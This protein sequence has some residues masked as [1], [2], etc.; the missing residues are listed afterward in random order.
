MT[1]PKD[2]ITKT[3]IIVLVLLGL[4]VGVLAWTNSI[5]KA[6]PASN[7][8]M[9]ALQLAITHNKQGILYLDAG[10]P[11]HAINE[12]KLGIMLNPNSTMS[13][14]LYNNLG[15]SYEMIKEYNYAITAYEHAI[16]INPNFSV[17]YK[18][19][20]NVYKSKKQLPKAR[21]NYEK[22]MEINPQDAQ[23]CFILALIYMEDGDNN[24]AKEALKKFIELEPKLDL[25]MAAKKYLKQLEK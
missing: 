3:C 13:A 19:L 23:A 24:K 5:K 1:K 18:N 2:L 9:N 17:Y 22:I 14:T 16:K 6:D 10:Y 11:L 7:T 8:S 21:L 20:V 15:R 4:Q 12:F 25:A